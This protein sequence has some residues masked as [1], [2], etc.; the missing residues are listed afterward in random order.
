[1]NLKNLI[2]IL[3][4]PL[5]IFAFLTTTMV[6]WH[7]ILSSFFDQSIFFRNDLYN[8]LI[9]FFLL[10]IIL[11]FGLKYLNL[12]LFE[13]LSLLPKIFIYLSFFITV[14]STGFFLIALITEFSRFIKSFSGIG[15]KIHECFE[16]QVVEIP[17]SEKIQCS[18]SFFDSNYVAFAFGLLFSVSIMLYFFKYI[19]GI[20]LIKFEGYLFVIMCI[21]IFFALIVSVNPIYAIKL[22]SYGRNITEVENINRKIV[23]NAYR[24]DEESVKTYLTDHEN[25]YICISEDD[26]NKNNYVFKSLRND[27]QNVN[28]KYGICTSN[29]PKIE[30][31]VDNIDR[32]RIFYSPSAIGGFIGLSL[33]TSVICYDYVYY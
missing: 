32:L 24:F 23:N 15:I 17:L 29:L 28:G 21:T 19:K 16:I 3:V 12:V 7:E 5:V 10:S 20:R 31:T 18:L 30:L 22:R 13:S 25:Y 33:N 14:I 11:I 27:I 9:P 2:S 26:C 1:M 8:V 6:I 4:M